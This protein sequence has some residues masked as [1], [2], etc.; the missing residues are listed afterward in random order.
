M[1][2]SNAGTYRGRVLNAAVNSSKNGFPQLAANLVADEFWDTDGEQPA[3]VGLQDKPEIDTYMVLVDGKGDKT[4]NC[5]QVETVL[6]WDG[7]SL[8]DLDNM[9][10]AEKQV[11]FR[12]E[13]REYNGKQQIQ[14]TWL[15][16]Y[17]A[18]PGRKVSKLEPDAVK[19]MQAKFAK[20]LGGKSMKPAVA[21]KATPAVPGKK[22]AVPVVNP[23][24]APGKVPM[25]KPTTPKVPAAPGGKCSMEE[26]FAYITNQELWQKDVDQKK[27]EDTRLCVIEEIAGNKADADITPDEWYKIKEKV[28]SLVFV[29]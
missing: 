12:V 15:S 24:V 5:K 16:E 20:A 4:L 22:P 27:V 19:A 6:G 13:E 7:V 1:R 23:V 18:I 11:Q 21:P 25:R 2:I 28:A 14:V 10:F 3:W 8:V 9:E 17:D 29:F 26:A